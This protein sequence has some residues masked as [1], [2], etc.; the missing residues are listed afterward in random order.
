MSTARLSDD[1]MLGSIRVKPGFGE[2]AED[3]GF[4]D[5]DALLHVL[6][7]GFFQQ[8][9]S[10]DGKQSGQNRGATSSTP[11]DVIGVA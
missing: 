11:F 6:P 7:R 1:S 4:V 8:I 2:A 9:E 10:F 3:R 5:F